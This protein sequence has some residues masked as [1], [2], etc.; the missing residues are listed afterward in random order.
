MNT[1]SRNERRWRAYKTESGNC[2]VD[3]FLETLPDVDFIEVA[4]AMKE[5]RLDG[6]AAARHLRGDIYEVRADGTGVIYRV[7]FAAEGRF[8]HIL[9]ALEALKKKSRATPPAKIALA[10]RPLADW[11]RRGELSKSPAAR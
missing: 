2:P 9:L 3:E 1:A 8:K 11:R 4:A 6:L 10:E 7:L 5:V